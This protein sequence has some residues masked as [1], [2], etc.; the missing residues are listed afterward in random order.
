MLTLFAIVIAFTHAVAH[1][2]LA[3]TA[4]AMAL[5]P[6]CG[7]RP[8]VNPR[9][10]CRI[11]RAAYNRE[12]RAEQQQR[13]GELGLNSAG[14]QRRRQHRAHKKSTD[15]E[16][17]PAGLAGEVNASSGFQEASPLA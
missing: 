17:H 12:W 11:C 7:I 1:T 5:C 15:E 2:K 13:L 16:S 6:R 4:A 3:L 8:R 10:Y 9:T 14:R